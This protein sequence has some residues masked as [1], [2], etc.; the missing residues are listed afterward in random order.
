MKKSK[1]TFGKNFITKRYLNSKFDK[2]LNQNYNNIIKNITLNLD[3]TKDSF[4]S[5]SK[6]FKFN[7]KIKEIEKFK[8]FKTVMIIGMGGSILGAQAIYSFLN[9][10]IKKEFYFFDNLDEDKILQIKKKKDL[11]KYFLLL[12]LN[13]VTQLK[14]Y[15][16]FLI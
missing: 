13:R 1:S 4:H 8:K 16:I 11:T 5:L 12:Y 14:H 3:N 6:N 7:F 2:K 10:K 9:K 15:Q